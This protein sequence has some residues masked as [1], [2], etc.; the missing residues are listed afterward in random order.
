MTALRP[1]QIDLFIEMLAEVHVPKRAAELAGIG[2]SSAYQHKKKD[3]LFAARWA[4]AQREAVDVL[5]TEARRRAVEGVKKPY[6]YKGKQ[7]GTVLEHSDKLLEFLLMSWDRATY[8]RQTKSEVDMKNNIAIAPTEQSDIEL[9]RRLAFVL[10]K[11]VK[12][13]EK[14]TGDLAKVVDVQV[15]ETEPK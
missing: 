5:A 6:W 2:V 4:D 7:V 15:E 11:G 12:A 8:G 3:G 1:D 10:N 13:Q 14:L 9:A